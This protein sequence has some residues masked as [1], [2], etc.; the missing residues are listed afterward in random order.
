MANM[1]DIDLI[2]SYPIEDPERIAHDSHDPHVGA[3]RDA[4]SRIWHPANAVN[5]FPKTAL[6]ELSYR[7]ARIGRIVIRNLLEIGEPVANRQ[8]SFRT[9]F[10]EG[11]F[12]VAFA[13]HF[14][15]IN[16]RHCGVNDLQFLLRGYVVIVSQFAFDL[17][18]DRHQFVL[19]CHRPALDAFQKV[20]QV[21]FR[22][23]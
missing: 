7:R 13:R 11:S 15:C 23:A 10:S 16:G 12:D 4:R 20:F 8:A 21:S 14:P 19:R 9:K 18:G 1:Q 17:V 22:H 6:D 2:P 5:N 3:L